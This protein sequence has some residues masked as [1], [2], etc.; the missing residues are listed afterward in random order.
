MSN[1]EDQDTPVDDNEQARDRS[2]ATSPRKRNGSSS[3][4]GDGPNSK[5]F[6]II[7]EEEEYKWSLPQDMASYAHDNSEKYIP[8]KDV[9]EAHM[10]KTPRPEN[11]DPVKKLDDYLQ[12]LLKQKKRPQYISIYYTLE[13]VQDKVLCIIGPLPKLWVMVEQV[14]SGNGSSSTVEMDTILELLEK[15]V[16][17][18]GQCNNTITYEKKKMFYLA[19]QGPP[20]HKWLQC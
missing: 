16:L 7:T 12:E 1:S 3:Q 5:R 10:I 18:I 19:S 6:R 11:L 14:N 4:G 2:E 9:K 20:H 13:K 17:L 8:E 15:T